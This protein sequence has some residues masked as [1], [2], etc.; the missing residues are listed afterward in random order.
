MNWSSGGSTTYAE[1]TATRVAEYS[2]NSYK[3]L[4][5]IAP[6]PKRK[7]PRRRKKCERDLLKFCETYYPA[8]FSLEWSP[9]HLIFI[10]ELQDRLLNGGK[11]S[12]AMPRGSGKTSLVI[13]AAQWAALFGHRSFLFL[14]AVSDS[15][16]KQ[17][18]DVLKMDLTTNERLFE[19]FPEVCHPIRKLENKS[20]KTK[21]QT[22]KKKFTSCQWAQNRV[23]L[24]DIPKS[25]SRQCIFQS[26]GI[27][28]GEIRGAIYTTPSGE[29]RRPDMVLL[30]DPQ[31]DEVALSLAQCEKRE[32]LID[33]AVL[34]MAGPTTQISAFMTCTIIADGDLSSTYLSR[35]KKPEW[36]GSVCGMVR[37]MPDNLS[38]W[39]EYKN[40]RDEELEAG[41][42][43]SS[44]NTF[45]EQN[46]ED[47]EKG[48]EVS[49]PERVE[50][51]CISAIQ[52]AMH[53]YLYVPE[54]FAAEYQ[55]SPLAKDDTSKQ[56][57]RPE[58][59][60]VKQNA[61]ARRKIPS[62]CHT[63]VTH[64]DVQKKCLYYTVLAVE[65][66]F[67]CHVIDYGTFPE[68]RANYY[69]LTGIRST[70]ARKYPGAGL[71]GSIHAGLVDL[72]QSLE[73]TEWKKDN[74]DLL[75][76]NLGLID[77]GWGESTDVVRKVCRDIPQKGRF[78][79][80]FGRGVLATS[81]PLTATKKK[82]GERRGIGWR[83]LPV[84]GMPLKQVLFDA[85]MMKS[86]AHE[87]LSVA[88][89]APGCMTLYKAKPTLHRMFSEQLRS[90]TATDVEA[91]G[92]KKREW[93]LRPDRPDNHF[94]DNLA[95]CVCAAMISG[96][97]LDEH[98]TNVTKRKRR[99]TLKL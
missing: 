29:M 10:N 49:W 66:R 54:S 27:T 71:E 65:D 32:R 25:M 60:A 84:D 57:L 35:K 58:E 47:L 26:A 52:T 90:E 86:F 2:R 39:D 45:Y 12:Q 6:L 56:L 5:E 11:K 42:D 31:D 63:L 37:S 51:G 92:N 22:F 21:A 15:K 75:T 38:L 48:A 24:P 69:T 80:A 72:I 79:P 88:V 20:I 18:I 23:V 94:L 40:H 59:I 98:Q 19:D 30:D 9:D 4:N 93:K 96:C 87:R 68:Q 28:S 77:A 50:G 70:L 36:R 89:G 64:I 34:G 1:R 97:A 44:A 8:R 91:N 3:Q 14:I 7:N 67:S 95:G 43:G 16:A 83:Q 17:L 53:K 74:G 78:L 99:R 85:N 61:H 33:G 82:P 46:R 62:E 81:R 13:T 73:D 41:G 55:N 76:I